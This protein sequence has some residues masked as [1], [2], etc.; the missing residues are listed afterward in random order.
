MAL[1]V[2]AEKP[3]FYVSRRSFGMTKQR[4]SRLVCEFF[5]FNSGHNLIESAPWHT[6]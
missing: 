2:E 3:T 1:R 4:S 6:E 5:S